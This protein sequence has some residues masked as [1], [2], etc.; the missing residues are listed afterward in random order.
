MVTFQAEEKR[1]AVPGV[2]IS[3][4]GSGR[5][6]RRQKGR[7]ASRREHSLTS[8]TPLLFF[9]LRSLSAVRLEQAKAEEKRAKKR[10]FISTC[11]QIKR[12]VHTGD[13]NDNNAYFLC[14]FPRLHSQ[15]ADH[16][17]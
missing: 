4:S 10:Y 1:K 2:R 16:A 6:I 3:E 9:L 5:N 17:A 8:L 12:V 11:N 7:E 14:L 13:D 15:Q